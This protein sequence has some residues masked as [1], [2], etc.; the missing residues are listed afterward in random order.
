MLSREKKAELSR[1]IRDSQPIQPI[2]KHL[3]CDECGAYWPAEDMVDTLT[4]KKKEVCPSCSRARVAYETQ[5]A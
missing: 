2:G 3:A 1:A 5:A 4:G